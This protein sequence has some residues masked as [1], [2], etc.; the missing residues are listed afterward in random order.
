[1]RLPDALGRVELDPAASGE[2]ALLIWANG[3]ARGTLSSPSAFQ[4]LTVRVRGSSCEGPARFT[5]R[6]DGRAVLAAAASNGYTTF[7]ASVSGAAGN[8]ELSVS[9]DNDRYR[10]RTCDRNIWVDLIRI[11]TS[12]NGDP[13]TAPSPTEPAP[14][15]PA[16]TQPAPASHP[17]LFAAS[18]LWNTDKSSQSLTFAT[19]ADK[20]LSSLSYGLNNGAFSRPVYFA[21]AN[22]PLVTFRLGAGWGFPAATVQI[23]LPSGARQASGS[24]AVMS[25]LQ[26]DGTLFDLYGVSG[27]GTSWSAQFYGRSNGITG[28]GFGNPQTLQAAGTT[29]IGS[30]QA[31]G[32]ILARDIDAVN[33]GALDFG[34]AISM[35]FDYM[36]SGG[37]GTSGKPQV[38]PAVANDVGGGPGP[39]PQGGLMVIP[40]GTPMPSGL[41]VAGKAL[42][43]SL[44]TYGAYN[45]DKLG[46]NPMFYGDGSSKVGSALS[47]NDLTLCGRALR[48]VRTW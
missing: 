1:M 45:T 14:T 41:S 9:F 29:A 38:L 23:R 34:H 43:R 27:G 2:R 16:P 10:S 46:G 18:S 37:A 17:R 32:V 12:R 20:L 22:D 40:P 3:T 39:I 13:G 11:H 7:R 48:L 26:P 28:S 42:W 5:V 25:V 30:P 4:E 21:T 36:H 31:G 15:Q 33:G 19:G 8:R 24:D 44:A 35:A 47:A 6:L